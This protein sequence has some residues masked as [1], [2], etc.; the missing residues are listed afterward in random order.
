MAWAGL[1]AA[2]PMM[3]IQL[4][5]ERL[6]S[7]L[8]PAAA[9]VL[10][11]IQGIQAAWGTV[12]QII[13]AFSLFF[14]F[15]KAVKGGSAGPQFATALASAAIVVIQF[16]AFFLLRK[17]M[18]PASKIGAKIR[19]I[20]KKIGDSLKKVGKAVVKGVKAVG[21]GVKTAAKA[22]A[23]GVKRAAKALGRGLKKVGKAIKKSKLF[24]AL[25]KT[26]VGKAIIRGYRKAQAL[27]GKAK[28]RVKKFF[29]D[30]KKKKGDPQKRLD[31]AVKEIRPAVQSLL[32]R[33]VSTVRL[34]LTL[35]YYQAKH[36][37]RSLKIHG[38]GRRGTI[39][40]KINPE[41]KTNEF[42]PTPVQD[43][44]LRII[45]DAGRDL[46]ESAEAKAAEAELNNQRVRGLGGTPETPLQLQ[47]GAGNLGQ[48]RD[49]RRFS[50][51]RARG[52]T[53]HLTGPGGGILAEQQL[54]YPQTGVGTIHVQ[55]LGESGTYQEIG[56]SLRAIKDLTGATDTEIAVALRSVAQG[57]PLTG[58]L[59]GQLQSGEVRNTFTAL[60]RLFNVEGARSTAA[61]AQGPMLLELVASKKLTFDKAF[62]GGGKFSGGLFPPSQVGAVAAARGVEGELDA[63]AGSRRSNA[64]A[65]AE[66]RRRQVEFAVRYVQLLMQAE[67]LD[68]EDRGAMTEFIRTTA[69]GGSEPEPRRV[70]QRARN[71]RKRM[72]HL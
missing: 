33:G 22:V 53:E 72:R 65:Q 48:V 15:L 16:V 32:H 21:R 35:G 52:E 6:V 51:I 36:G 8:V 9:A 50:N 54:G 60:N 41:E 5:I 17:L 13:K 57:R 19:A 66:Q 18:S 28:R 67:R 49:V 42:L 56:T 68:F 39:V 23:K 2:I 10:A 63:P 34:W 58:R 45:R 44:L 24:K 11:I 69:Q 55:G 26:K 64:Q 70:L 31:R 1:K 47:G 46:L 29:A 37:L 14:T 3:L 27:Y 62:L 20:A 59:A 71:R 30:R 7:M 40:A 25:A 43:E 38:E 61:V 12:Q 4:L